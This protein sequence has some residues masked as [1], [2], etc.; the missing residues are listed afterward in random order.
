MRPDT[1]QTPQ[2]LRPCFS[3]G[4]CACDGGM[5]SRRVDTDDGDDE[6]VRSSTSF[7]AA[8]ERS[9]LPFLMLLWKS[10]DLAPSSRIE[11]QDTVPLNSTS[12]HRSFAALFRFPARLRLKKRVAV[13]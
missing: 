12:E 7:S 10:G 3:Y 1:Y 2:A 9:R 11:N 6:A 8:S 5:V 4:M 13:R